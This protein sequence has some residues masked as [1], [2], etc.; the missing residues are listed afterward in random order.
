MRIRLSNPPVTEVVLTTYFDP[1]LRSL[2]N[3]HVGRFWSTIE[4]DFPRVEQKPPL[5]ISND[6]SDGLVSPDEIFPMPRYW[7][8]SKDSSEV[9]QIHKQAF[10]YNWRNFS[11]NAYPGFH[12]RVMPAFDKYSQAF[13]NFLRDHT[14][15]N[16][17]QVNKCELT[18]VNTVEQ[19]EYWTG[20]DDTSTVVPS[21]ST[22]EQIGREGPS[23]DF[24]HMYRYECS[25]KDEVQIAIRSA[26]QRSNPDIT[27]LILQLEFTSDTLN[28]TRDE[29]VT[30]FP[31][32]HRQIS[33]IFAGITN[34]RIRQQYW[35]SNE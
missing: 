6:Q 14:G 30:W 2:K 31:G 29:A 3:E 21:F 33:E 7:F 12:E 4:L 32:A 26:R 28:R 17:P 13:I 15:E 9:I 20:P 24:S 11:D 27:A 10:T 18:Y 8:I 1:I 35:G 34:P 23:N 5:S 25:S 19:C 16:E 22:I